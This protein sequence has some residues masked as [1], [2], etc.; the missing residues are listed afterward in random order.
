[1]PVNAFLLILGVD[2]N[3]CGGD[4]NAAIPAPCQVTLHPRTSDT[5]DALKVLGMSTGGLTWFVLI[6]ALGVVLAGAAL[7]SL[8]A[9]QQNSQLAL[10][11]RRMIIAGG[12]AATFVG[13]MPFLITFWVNLA[14]SM[15]G[16]N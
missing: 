1:M 11:A 8:S 16:G 9:S 12:L 6:I 3:R 14:N 4:P 2:S 15:S 7:W 13:M 10:I 5:A